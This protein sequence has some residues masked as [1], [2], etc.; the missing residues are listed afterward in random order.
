[1]NFENKDSLQ[2]PSTDRGVVNTSV[3]INTDFKEVD[4][5]I[6]WFQCTIQGN[7]VED[8]VK[9]VFHTSL[10]NCL[11]TPSGRFGYNNTYTY[12]STIHIMY[13]DIRSD[14]GVH[15]ML[16]GSACREL[17]DLITFKDFFERII[18]FEVCKVTRIDIAI[19]T[20]KKYFDIASLR[21]KISDA[22]LVSKFRKGTFIEQINV[23]DGSQE[24]ASLKFGSMSSDIYIVFYDK[25]AER[26]NAGY[27]VDDSVDFWLRTELRFK[28]DLAVL[29]LFKIT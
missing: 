6:D 4:V 14:M 1:M 26:K 8:V 18:L 5:V 21:K 19:D 13:H 17:E 2:P 11:H 27:T 10:E 12:A 23:S 25:L 24:S 7:D 15:I 22:E 28:H 3:C 20:Y 16:S 29:Q 9:K